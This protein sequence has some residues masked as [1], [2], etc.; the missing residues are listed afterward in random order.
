M[1]SKLH[2]AEQ[3]YLHLEATLADPA[4]ASDP[5]RYTATMKEY[6]SLSPIIEAYRAHRRAQETV[7]ELLELLESETDADMRQMATEELRGAK[8]D[9]LRLERELTLLLLP[10]D[11]NDEK[12]VIVEIRAGA[13]GALCFGSVSH[14]Y[15]V[16]RFGRLS[17]VSDFQK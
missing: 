17:V 7:R 11:P 14:V 2:Q 1:Q 4:V 13:G 15:H 9:V 16:C 12:N 10:R 5:A 3:K 8:E 6:R